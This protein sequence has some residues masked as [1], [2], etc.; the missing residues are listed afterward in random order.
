MNV[1]IYVRVSTD[2]QAKEGFSIP[3]QR[4]RLKAFV[5]SQGWGSYEEYIEEG[6][7][8]KDINRP[9]IQR[10]LQDIE[11]GK[12]DIV[13]VYR[14]D[15]LTRS[16]LDLYSLLQIFD[17]HNVAFRSAT[18]V[19]DTSTAMGRLFITL[20]A[21]LA[22]WE[23][24]NLAERVRFGIEQMIDDG[25]KPGGHSAFG[26]HFDKDFNC[27]IIEE[28][29]KIVNMIYQWYADGIGYHTIAKKLNKLEVKPRIAKQWNPNS[30]R[31][32]LMND[33]YIGTY[34]W[35]IKIREKNHTPI[36]SE[37]L[38]KKVSNLLGTKSVRSSRHG[39]NILTGIAKCG[40]CEHPVSA[41]FD[42]RDKRI[43]YRCTKCH[44]TIA[45]NKILDVVINE[46]E[47]LISDWNY[48]VKKVNQQT[49]QPEVNI[50]EIT[51]QIT[52]IK[53][54]KEKWYDLFTDDD[55]PIPKDDL[56]ARI[57]KL[58]EKENEL[59]EILNNTVVVLETPE[60]KYNKF[61]FMKDIK[62]QFELADA[63]DKKELLSAVFETIFLF[64][65]KGKDKPLKIKYTI[66]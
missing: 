47:K 58:N 31:D 50:D 19:Y 17:N 59:Q 30:I 42:K 11:R 33:M 43:Y 53:N 49:P 12:I 22:Q 2:D 64:K 27:K 35:G 55:N 6:W 51:K 1:A 46:L 13:L 10:M 62:K 61:K 3:A 60:E 28:E 37:V 32:I 57:N 8:A 54:Q 7:S 63:D 56:F 4:E 52:K 5:S 41:N 29:A 24:E 14:L 9:Q 20:V 23:R 16:V 40:Y 36:I 25:K 66:K 44:R 34:R 39:K 38:F 15:R 26:Y 65:E 48:F 21:A 18:E 45:E